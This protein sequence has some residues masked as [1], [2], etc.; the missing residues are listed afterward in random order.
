[1]RTK[2]NR[3][4]ILLACIF[5]LGSCHDDDGFRPCIKG[6]GDIN[7]ETRLL[8]DFESVDYKL[9]GAVEIR[10]GEQS[11]VLLEGYSNQLVHVSTKVEQGRLKIYSSRCLK[12]TKFRCV[13]YTSELE[14]LKLSGSGEGYIRDSFSSEEMRFELSG[15]GCVD[16][17]AQAAAK[18]RARISGSGNMKIE[19]E[20]QS[21]RADVSGSGRIHAFNLVTSAMEANLSGSGSVD[22]FVTNRLDA[23]IS[24]SG[25]IR[26]KGNPSVVNAH[27]S[28]SG[29]VLKVE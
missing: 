28:G 15:S 13:V 17:V 25:T 21:F 27:V 29:K 23:N 26:Y 1:M 22:A 12:N 3:T 11:K 10:K 9:E 14:D 5:A 16:A 2:K 19:G 18:I 20:C 6:N 4:L 24:G 8:A 7:S